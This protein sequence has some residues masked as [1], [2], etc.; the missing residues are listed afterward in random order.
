MF[1]KFGG[2]KFWVSVLNERWPPARPPGLKREDGAFSWGRPGCRLWVPGHCSNATRGL[3]VP[4]R[5]EKDGQFS[6]RKTAI[7]TFHSKVE[8]NGETEKEGEEEEKEERRAAESKP[9]VLWNIRLGLTFPPQLTEALP[10][11]NNDLIVS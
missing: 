1:A 11:A 3:Q 5:A 7:L 8:T 6:S 10:L 2:I 9:A 4:A